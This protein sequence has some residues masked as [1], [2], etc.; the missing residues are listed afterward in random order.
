MDILEFK[1]G[2]VQV[3][4]A[5]AIQPEYLALKRAVKNTDQLD[6]YLT[7][8]W[9]QYYPL[10][11]LRN[12]LPKERATYIETQ[13]F[14]G[15]YKFGEWDS[16]HAAFVSFYV[17]ASTSF[18]VRS[19]EQ[20]K[21]DIEDLLH[22]ISTIPFKKKVLLKNQKVEFE[23]EGQMREAYINIT[24]ELDNSDEKTKALKMSETLYELEERLR[25]KVIQEEFI[26]ETQTHTMIEQDQ[27]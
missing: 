8:L 7:Y 26:K 24:V 25:R 27:S 9:L 22:H 20:L 15:R 11:T 3:T 19:Y 14:N 21:V 17:K 5:G 23:N 2:K 16:K 1:N 18:I 10:S 12:Y 6:D 13:M 4:P